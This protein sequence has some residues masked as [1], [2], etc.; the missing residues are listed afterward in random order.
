MNIIVSGS[1]NLLRTPLLWFRG[2]IER[3]LLVLIF[4]SS[5]F[6]SSCSTLPLDTK[7]T[8]PSRPNILL[9]VVDDMGSADLGVFGSEISTP[10]L[11]SLAKSGVIFTNFHTSPVCSATRAML[12]TGV[13]N[14]L[15]GFGN[16]AEELATNQKGMSGYE[17]ELNDRVVTLAT[18]LQDHGYRTYISGKWH[19]GMSENSSPRAR[20]FDRS[21]AML[22]GG[23]SHYSDMRPAY[24]P[25]PDGVAP[26]REN[27]MMLEELPS[28]FE[29][30]TQF[31]TDRMINYI[32]ETAH[33]KPF[34]A[35]LAYTAPHWPLQ[36]PE[37][38]INKYTGVYN[39]GF[40][41]IITKRL[42]RQKELGIVPADAQPNPPTIKSVDWNTLS[43][44]DKRIQIRS[45][46]IYAAMV[47]EI[48]QH[49]GRLLRFLEARN[50]LENTIVVFLSDNGAE[51]HDL[52]E[53]WPADQF[54]EIRYNIDTRHDFSY[55]NMGKPGSYVLYGP[56]WAR[57]GN[58]A[59]R[60]H[61]GFP[62]E[63]GTRVP[64]FITFPK[65][66]NAGVR[67]YFVSVLDVMPTILDLFEIPHPASSSESS[68]LM[69]MSGFSMLPTLNG[70][71]MVEGELERVFV[72]EILG[73]YFVR[74]GD[75]KL[76]FVTSPY[77]PSEWELFNISDDLTETNDLS[78]VFPDKV[79]ELNLEWEEYAKRNNVIL[80]N[81]VSGY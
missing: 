10:N 77:G 68:N 23:A 54:P 78:E 52:D 40:D 60:L 71:R 65:N 24:H 41:A 62:T 55:E 15:S 4:V 64:A 32:D 81:W 30:S 45:M 66:F 67:D 73:K 6:V 11:D 29:Y 47:D 26:Y 37:S 14:H 75:W 42:R 19:L 3:F 44:E 51:G 27:G 7:R 46:E 61:K 9:I 57:T 63:G 25:D 34:F 48:D 79:A 70:L 33:D 43:E 17:G 76:V 50:L 53:T 49:V 28:D 39:E 58:P 21:F 59:Y 20:G 18:I 72:G 69:P 8:K 16:M 56:D 36:A 13:D 31:F 1:V 35:Y 38:T 74:K 12:L 22:A 2:L 5:L 80:P